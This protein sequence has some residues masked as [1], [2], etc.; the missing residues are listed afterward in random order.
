MNNV[1]HSESEIKDNLRKNINYY[2]PLISKK[3]LKKILTTIMILILVFTVTYLYHFL[4]KK[5]GKDIAYSYVHFPFI[6]IGSIF[7]IFAI[8]KLQYQIT[9]LKNETE[10]K[11]VKELSKITQQIVVDG[12]EDDPLKH[13]ELNELYIKV[14][15]K[16]GGGTNGFLTKEQWESLNINVPYVPFEG[17]ESKWHYS[18]KFIQEMVN[19][20]RMN[21]LNKKYKINNPVDLEK[22]KMTE[23][24]GW[25]SSFRMWMSVPI[26]RNVFE[27]YK[28]RHVN[29][30]F[31]AWIKY[32]I[33][34]P[35]DKDPNYW[36]N[37][38]KVWDNNVDILL[39]KN[40]K[41]I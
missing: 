17:N 30:E 37:H 10:D 22:S 39:N 4:S 21:N 2:E 40:L 25:L 3:I 36:T 34:D 28:Y 38:K 6:F 29:P 7:V 12:W 16:P 13:P 1:T 33:T 20:Y 11:N 24:S 35:I 32:F 19:I 41:N 23:Y 26:V 14:F 15:S 8:Y 27:Q 9:H 18:A 5:Y 31:T